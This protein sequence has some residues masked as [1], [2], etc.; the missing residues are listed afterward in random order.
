MRNGDF[1]KEAVL[2]SPSGKQTVLQDA[3]GQGSSDAAAIN[4]SGQSVGYSATIG[5]DDAVLWSPSGQATVLQNAPGSIQSVAVAINDAGQSVGFS[6]TANGQ[7][8][9]LWSPS[10]KAIV[11]QNLSGG[12]YSN[13]SAIN[14]AG[15]SVG[16]SIVSG[17][18]TDAVLWSPSGKVTNLATL[19]GPAWS[20]TDAIGI[21][22]SGDIIGYGKYQHEIA[23]FLLMHVS[24]ASPDDYHA[25]FSA[26]GSVSAMAAH[27]LDL[28]H[29]S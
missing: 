13:V 4:A 6:K 19:L 16:V 17:V 5:G 14:D 2:W 10:G 24:G 26:A 7:D 28:S 15:E 3:G 29:R 20:D 21:N 18:A 11:L 23:S 1:R 9:V 25:T 12:D 27:N 8:A 22:N